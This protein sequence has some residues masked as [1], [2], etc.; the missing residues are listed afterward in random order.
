M[1]L[2]GIIPLYKS[3]KTQ[4]IDRYRFDYKAGKATFDV[5]FFIDSSPYLLLF[6]VKAENFSFELEVLNGFV[7][8][9][10]IDNDT[11]KRL[12]KV[13]GLEF[14]PNRPFST[15]NFFKEFNS[16]IPLT[17]NTSNPVKP[18]DIAPYQSVAE[19]ADKIYFVGWRDNSKW[20]TQVQDSNLEKTR[21]L[22]GEKAYLRCKQKNIS[23]CWSD[24]KDST[25]K[26]TLP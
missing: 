13:L 16:K 3:M 7:I 11:Y 18:Q 24:K 8:E 21:K 15:W 4:N 20:G 2:D 14:D 12:C 5:F 17:A 9:T 6:G 25:I 19:E 1:K 26:V 23:S 10:K 22:L